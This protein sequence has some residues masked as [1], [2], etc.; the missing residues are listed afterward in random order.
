MTVKEVIE[1]LQKCS[2]DA[3]VCAEANT[4]CLVNVIQEY[5]TPGG[6]KYVYVAD[7]TDYLDEVM[8][9]GTIKVLRR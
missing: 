8:E 4:D 5:H 9:D 2:P 6:Q 7:E 1:K 3:I